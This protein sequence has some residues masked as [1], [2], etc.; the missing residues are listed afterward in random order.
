MDQIKQLPKGLLAALEE[1]GYPLAPTACV[2]ADM[3]NEG[4][5]RYL[6]LLLTETHL[7]FV[8]TALSE[9]MQF[10][11]IPCRPVTS[12]RYTPIR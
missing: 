6:Y 11:G 4:E 7:V 2:Q 3:T 8:V 10:A 9:E 5:L 1:K 12:N